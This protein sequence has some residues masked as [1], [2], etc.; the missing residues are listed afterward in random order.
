VLESAEIALAAGDVDEAR[1]LVA[2]IASPAEALPL[3][4]C[5]GF[6]WTSA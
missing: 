2:S 3:L 4:M 6:V 1:R 5:S